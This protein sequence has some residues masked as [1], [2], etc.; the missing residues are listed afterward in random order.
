MTTNSPPS[1]QTLNTIQ[2]SIQ[3]GNFAQAALDAKSLLA[4]ATDAETQTMCWY[5]LAVS[6]R[7]QQAHE[8]A[9]NALHSLLAIHP[10]HARGFQELGYNYRALG[11]GKQASIHFYK[12]TKA[13]PALLS[14]WQALLPIYK[15]AGQSEA[16]ALCQTQI[17]QLSALPK[18]ILAATDLLYSGKIAEADIMCR[19]YLQE[20]K[21]SIEGLLL[22]AE[23]ALELKAISEAEFILETAIELDPARLKVKYHLFRIYSKLGKFAKALALATILTDKDPDNIF[24]QVAKGTALVGVGALNE[25]IAT[26]L[27][28]VAKKQVEAN[29]YLLLGHAYKTQG[30]I[31]ASVS[32]Y[33]QAYNIDPH[34]GDAYWSLAN[35]KTYVFSDA[36]IENMLNGTKHQD[37]S[38]TNKVHL[39]FALGK[40]YEDR[41]DASPEDSA[42]AEQNTLGKETKISRDPQAQYKE[43]F[44]HYAMGNQ[45]QGASLQYS[46]K[47]HAQFV[48]SQINTF[49]PA[50]V[51]KLK[52]LGHSDA[53]PIFIVGMPRAGSTL[54]E[55][56][57]ASHSQVDG[58]MELH[59]ILGLAATL[60]KKQHNKPSYPHNL[61]N[62]PEAYFAQFGEKFIKDTKVYRQ[63]GAYFIDKMPNN[64]MHIG[65]I[66]LIL[67][68]AKIIDARREPM[69]CCFSGFKQLFG[70][71]QEFSYSL[72]DIGLY[73]QNYI[74][75]MD[76]WQQLFPD[77]ILL[78]NH[79]DM[80][81][82]TQ[83]Q[84][85]RMLAF[86]GLEFEQACVDFHKNKRAVKTPSAQQVRQ[87]IYSSGLE[88]WKHFEPYLQELKDSLDGGAA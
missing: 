10:Q 21:R 8:D 39:H 51:N 80:V 15:Q 77:Q 27:Q 25:A 63:G 1:A 59:E 33:Q 53:A 78:V 62:I 50:L 79:E 45:L 67:P 76:H 6:Y 46:S 20:H 87:P 32:A 37:I 66:K 23:I 73:Y 47:N 22:L 49:T 26:Y 36:E 60:S 64:Y 38:D 12:A 85:R 41:P 58:T 54:L 84:I 28:I 34:C 5:L 86:C 31:K 11:Q 55:Q 30:D 65:L 68:K 69:A 16:I 74:K 29:V 71:G 56:I 43:A 42:H 4:S 61:E 18:P 70:E 40:A 24:Y 9:I 83:A 3:Q 44:T 14:A 35:T 81:S 75:L 52:H 57:L 17:T 72:T 48:Q 13:N 88:Q 82:D 7:L 2:Q 19:R